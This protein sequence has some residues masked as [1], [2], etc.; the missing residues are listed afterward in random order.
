MCQGEL[1]TFPHGPSTPG[2]FSRGREKGRKK[3]ILRTL[4]ARP[5]L[6]RVGEG[7]LVLGN[8]AYASEILAQVVFCRLTKGFGSMD[9]FF[10]IFNRK[11]FIV[12]VVTDLANGL[13]FN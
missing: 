11:R 3:P 13:C 7:E 5:L 6:S 1:S 8:M 12:S 9:N 10:Y 4:I 2:P